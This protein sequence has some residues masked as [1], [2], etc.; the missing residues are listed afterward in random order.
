VPL[1]CQYTWYHW[2]PVKPKNMLF[3]VSSSWRSWVLEA[4]KFFWL[5][6]CLSNVFS[7]YVFMI[8]QRWQIFCWKNT[9]EFSHCNKCFSKFFLKNISSKEWKLSTKKITA[10]GATICWFTVNH[11]R[12]LFWL[13][14]VLF[15]WWLN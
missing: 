6:Q 10:W 15:D 14:R 5:I 8:F 3:I 11:T 9:F 2:Y 1:A 4:S 13:V 12:W 7:F